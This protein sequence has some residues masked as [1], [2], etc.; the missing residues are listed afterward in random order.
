MRMNSFFTLANCVNTVGIWSKNVDP[1]LQALNT[2]FGNRISSY[3]FYEFVLTSTLSTKGTHLVTD[4][5]SFKFFKIIYL[6]T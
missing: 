4:T 3:I 1:S 2:F 5:R 6:I